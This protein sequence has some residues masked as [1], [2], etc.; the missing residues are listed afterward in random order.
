M[1]STL[2]EHASS[3]ENSDE[4]ENAEART[5]GQKNLF[6]RTLTRF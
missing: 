4:D 3:E 1:D 5:S 6:A 2:D